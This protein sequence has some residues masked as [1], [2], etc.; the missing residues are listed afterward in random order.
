MAIELFGVTSATVLKYLSRLDGEI[1][2]AGDLLDDVEFAAI[3]SAHASR[4]NIELEALNT[5]VVSRIAAQTASPA[6]THVQ[7]II[8]RLCLSDVYRSIYEGSATPQSV[9]ALEERA[10]DELLD[11]TQRPGKIGVSD[12]FNQAASYYTALESDEYSMHNKYNGTNV[13]DRP[14]SE[15]W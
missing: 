14:R 8:A 1:G 12:D 4:V 7:D 2:S 6:Y 11:L 9:L 5:G 3:I 10:K 15:R 13:R